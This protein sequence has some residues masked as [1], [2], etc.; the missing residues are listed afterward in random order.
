MNEE[1]KNILFVLNV[2]DKAKENDIENQ[3]TK[4]GKTVLKR[5]HV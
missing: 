2:Y 4:N 5:R 3:P 1:K